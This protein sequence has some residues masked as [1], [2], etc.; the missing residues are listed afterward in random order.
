MS[1]RN[2]DSNSALVVVR[3]VQVHHRLRRGLQWLFGLALGSGYWRL[4]RTY[5]FAGLVLLAQPDTLEQPAEQ[6]TGM[7][8]NFF[9]ST[10][11]MASRPVLAATLPATSA[12]RP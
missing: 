1:S 11:S 4:R 8:Q 2:E 10:S 9:S 5:R 12:P 3:L 6:H 7:N